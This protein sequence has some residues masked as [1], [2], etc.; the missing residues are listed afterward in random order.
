MISPEN[1]AWAFFSDQHRQCDKENAAYDNKPL[2]NDNYYK[3]ASGQWV[4]VTAVFDC[5]DTARR[6]YKYGDV[7][8][9]GA[10]DRSTRTEVA[11]GK[12]YPPLP[13]AEAL[14]KAVKKKKSKSPAFRTGKISITDNNKILYDYFGE[15]ERFER[16]CRYYGD[17]LGD[18]TL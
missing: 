14:E 10:V 16:T 11:F 18:K 12:P 5:I 13:I 8:Y 4:L 3:D 17:G 1:V 6:N 7:K 15:Y 2:P 9:L